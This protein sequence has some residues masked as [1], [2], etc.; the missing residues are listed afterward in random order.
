MTSADISDVRSRAEVA[1]YDVS[2]A[3]GL[4]IY[5]ALRILRGPF[6]PY[7]IPDV[8]SRFSAVKGLPAR[9]G[10]KKIGFGGREAGAGKTF[11]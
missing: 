11:Q 4:L 1:T 10:R 5:Q 6:A 7:I 8:E 2:E 9:L 3:C